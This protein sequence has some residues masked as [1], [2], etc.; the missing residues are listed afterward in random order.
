[1]P[2]LNAW[3]CDPFLS[4]SSARPSPETGPKMGHLTPTCRRLNHVAASS[5]STKMDGVVF[6]LVLPCLLQELVDTSLLH[7]GLSL[8]SQESRQSK[9]HTCSQA[10]L[11]ILEEI[12]TLVVV[13]ANA[14]EVLCSR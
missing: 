1:M 3:V 4:S 14:A 9:V 2:D 6:S 7:R 5:F 8:V 10:C 11:V 12:C 13:C